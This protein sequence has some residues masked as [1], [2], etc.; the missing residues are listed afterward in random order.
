MQSAE[1]W[2]RSPLQSFLGYSMSRIGKAPIQI[3]NGVSVSIGANEISVKGPKGVL[4]MHL[5]K[6]KVQVEQEQNVLSVKFDR[7]ITEQKMFAGTTRSLLANMIQ[8]VVEPFEKTLLIIG[9]GYRSNV[10]GK[11]INLSLGYSHPVVYD[12]P[13]GVD[14]KPGDA[15]N[16]LVIFGADKQRVGQV[17]AEIRML[18]PVEPYQG[19]GIRYLNEQVISKEAKKAK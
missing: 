18:R 1:C 9:V 17:S 14:A 13:E 6:D 3:P 8:G 12:L 15:P 10:K 7:D 19:K 2:R 4:S 5:A 11:K 16:T